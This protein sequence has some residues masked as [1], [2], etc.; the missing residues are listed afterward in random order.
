MSWLNTLMT[1]GNF[2][3]RVL[4]LL[5]AGAQATAGDQV[6]LPGG[7]K[8]YKD[9][10]GQP[11]IK[12]ISDHPVGMTFTYFTDEPDEGE[13][14]EEKTDRSA[15]IIHLPRGGALLPGAIAPTF[16]VFRKG[17]A[18]IFD[19]TPQKLANGSV[20]SWVEFLVTLISGAKPTS[21]AGNVHI[22]LRETRDENGNVTGSEIYFR[23]GVGINVNAVNISAST[24]TITWQEESNSS[25]SYYMEQDRLVFSSPASADISQGVR[26]Q[27]KIAMELSSYQALAADSAAMVELG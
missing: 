19:A 26:V 16:Q 14:T 2:A 17:N 27:G 8:A 15:Q 9:C 23:F 13:E 3:G 12:N 5:P 25:G 6:Y 10:E 21:V 24:P 1:V 11:V 20:L 7:I 4:T 22:G 18:A